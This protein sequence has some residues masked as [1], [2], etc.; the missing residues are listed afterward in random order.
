M[1]ISV[2]TSSAIVSILFG[3]LVLAFPKFL[4]YFVGAYFLI[5]GLIQLFF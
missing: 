3:I 2:V 1:A 4:R 5:I